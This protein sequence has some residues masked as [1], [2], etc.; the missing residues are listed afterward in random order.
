MHNNLP[1]RFGASLLALVLV[2]SIC[3][4]L[5]SPASATENDAGDATETTQ[6]TELAATTET[7]EATQ[8]AESP[9]VDESDESDEGNE[10]DPRNGNQGYI[11]EYLDGDYAFIS[12]I[13]MKPDDTTESGTLLRT[14][15]GPW[16]ADNEPGND[17]SPLNNIVCTFDTINYTFQYT[18]TLRDDKLPDCG[19]IAR[20]RLYFQFI[21][22]GKA[23]EIMFDT[24]AMGWLKNAPDVCYKADDHG[25]FQLLRGSF[26]LEPTTTNPAA[27]GASTNEMSVIL[28]VLQMKNGET[29][30][31]IFTLW[32]QHNDVCG[33]YEEDDKLPAEIIT[34]QVQPTASTADQIQ[35]PVNQVLHLTPATVTVSARFMFNLEVSGFDARNNRVGYFNFDET[36][37]T[38][39]INYGLGTVEGRMS[40]IGL[41]LELLGKEDQGMRGV[42]FPDPGSDITFR[43]QLTSEFDP[44]GD[45]LRAPEPNYTALFWSGG[46]NYDEN[47]N[48]DGRTYGTQYDF[49]PTSV[50]NHFRENIGAQSAYA[51][52]VNGGK[53]TF[54]EKEVNGQKELWVTVEDFT[55]D[56]RHFPTGRA[57]DAM[58]GYTFYNPNTVNNYWEIRRATF[59]GGELWIVQPYEAI[60]GDNPGKHITAVYGVEGMFYT[61]A[62]ASDF[63]LNGSNLTE[64]ISSDNTKKQGQY[65][66]LPG[67]ISVC[68]LY[69]QGKSRNYRDPLT[70]GGYQD[71]LDWATIGTPVTL[72]AFIQHDKADDMFTGVAYDLLLKFDDEFFLPDNPVSYQAHK[73]G[74]IRHTI[75][76]GALP[77]VNGE[78]R[79]WSNDYDGNGVE[80]DDHMKTATI[81]DLIYYTSLQALYDD[82]LIPVAILVEYRGVAV[83]GGQNHLHCYIDGMVRRDCPQ[84]KI[85]MLTQNTYA[86]RKD[87]VAQQALDY[88][89]ATH[90][91]DY[92]SI[93]Q[94]TDADYNDYLYNAFPSRAKGTLMLFA[95]NSYSQAGGNGTDYPAPFWR[96]D[97]HFTHEK[98]SLPLNGAPTTLTPTALESAQKAWYEDG[99]YHP[100][101][102]AFYYE[103]SCLVM[104]YQVTVHKS[105]AQTE[106]SGN[107]KTYF[108][109]NRNQ[110]TVD[111]KVI[112]GLERRLSVNE[113]ENAPIDTVIYIEDLLP[114]SIAYVAGSAHLGGTYTQDASHQNQGSYQNSTP[115]KEVY[116]ITTEEPTAGCPILEI[117]TEKID[118]VDRTRLRF[119][120]KVTMD[121]KEA[122]FE[123]PI[124]FSCLIGTA[125]NESTD[126]VHDQNI[127]NTVTAWTPEDRLRP[128]TS[129]FGNASSCGISIQKTAAVSLSK[130]SDYLVVEQTDTMGFSMNAGNNSSQ[131][132]NNTLIMETLPFQGNHGT[133]FNGPL[134][135][136]GFHAAVVD[137]KNQIVPVNFSFY[138]TTEECYA[139]MISSDL[140]ALARQEGKSI[141]QWILDSGH[142]QSLTFST[143]PMPV[144]AMNI[145]LYQATNLPNLSPDT[146]ITAI[147]ALGDLPAAT[148]MKMHIDLKLPNGHP[149]DYLVNYLSQ[150][151][152]SSYA[153]SQIV[154]RNLE[155]LC[156]LD[157]NMDGIQDADEERLSGV[158]VTLVRLEGNDYVPV[159]FP[160]TTTPVTIMTGQTIS[161]NAQS[162]D[163][164]VTFEEGRYKFTDLPAGTYGVIFESGDTTSISGYTASPVGVGTNAA[165]DSDG[166]AT[167]RNGV[168][169]NTKISGIVMLTA[170]Q[171]TTG[172]QVSMY[173]DSGFYPAIHYE[174]PL[175]GGTGTGLLTALGF[176]LTAGAALSLNRKKRK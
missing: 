27:I 120:I 136:T 65:L 59:S 37:V 9:E 40:G 15:V 26:M 47:L 141:N 137:N 20:G 139:E 6:A 166:V 175:T 71:D 60:T 119:K 126:V 99:I 138:Y 95:G 134:I 159:C 80:D 112:A 167:Y 150:D 44:T 67:S 154:Q 14:G 152:L 41:R 176:L 173:H 48:A 133:H 109:M 94:L 142:W 163:A 3:S 5:V 174:L 90:E 115:F 7:T 28:R 170:D 168:L 18:T 61:S 104:P 4:G 102:G 68:L 1:R 143:S 155:G 82:G 66:R 101:N 58:S 56:T 83:E 113:A 24:E 55:I 75:L 123:Q 10:V 39:A 42:Q 122:S 32:L 12:D 72:E 171:L 21:V 78:A 73:S 128:R 125:G 103:D 23:T 169:Q 161:V 140:S 157:T 45:L 151:S 149:A 77:K 105:V 147:I 31:P 146:Q 100:G 164:A 81:D 86:W 70:P 121:S 22:P 145:D 89:N 91:A 111:Y 8:A 135:V 97:Y 57:S 129:D 62:T 172:H 19:G 110:R 108:D 96:Q 49:V 46:E 13:S 106:S 148:T 85:Y 93:T 25:A 156:W 43:L 144:E 35:G 160:N 2:L 64:V 87:S 127:I 54:Y 63:Q 118:G 107:T 117:I 74:N 51:D 132:R 88:Y 16:D 79:G 29:I 50:F 30:T 158:R 130:I 131:P 124:Y 53:W 165:A 92:N 76:W 33:S 17:M 84:G 36:P 34:A 11:K 98:G 69:L 162:G 116:G 153:R 52:C 38:D 114:A